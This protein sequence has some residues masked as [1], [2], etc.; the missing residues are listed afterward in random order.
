MDKHSGIYLRKVELHWFTLGPVKILYE[1]LKPDDHFRNPA[2]PELND[3]GVYM[4]LEKDTGKARYVGQAF[5]K[6]S[7]ALRRRVRWEIVKDGNGCAESVFYRK[8]K[9][10]RFNLILKVAHIKDAKENEIA[11][12]VDDKFMNAIERA[13]IF[14]RARAGDPLMNET[15][16]SSYR[17]GPIEVVNNGD[18]A[19]LPASI[20]L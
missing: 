16:K 20:V 8:C 13:L 6:S 2:F 11:V 15:G 5:N 12:K 19:P 4:Y 3:Y 18:F 17:L 10:D 1:V 7:M 9:V 14:E